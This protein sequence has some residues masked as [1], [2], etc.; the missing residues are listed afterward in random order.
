MKIFRIFLCFSL[1]AA[2]YACSGYD[3]SALVKRIE[4]LEKKVRT[5]QEQVSGINS[6][7][8]ALKVTLNAIDNQDVVVGIRA[9]ED[10]GK[11]GWEITYRK[12]GTV[13]IFPSEGT[14]SK[15]GVAEVGG[16]LYWTWGGSF[17]LDENGKRIPASAKNGTNGIT[18]KVKIEDDYWWV[19]YDEGATWTRLE[20]ATS[21]SGSGGGDSIFRSAYVEGNNL[22]IVLNNGTKLTIPVSSI[23]TP[24]AFDE[25]SIVFSVAA[26]SDVHI[27]NGYGS[28]AKFTSA[29][30]QLKNRAAEKDPDGLDAVMLVGDLI[31]TT[32]TGQISTLKSLYEGVFDPVKVPMIYTVG[33]HDMNPGCN[34]STNTVS[35]NAVFHTILG[36]DY[37]LTDKDQTMRRNFE[38]RHCVVGDYHIVGI[39]PNNANPVLYDANSTI[40]L[41]NV[42]EEI[43]TADPDRYVLVIT[44]PMIYN[45]VYGS[46]L[47]TYWYTSTLTDILNKYPQVVTFSGH[48]HFPLNDPRSIWQGKFTSMGC[49]SVSYM[50]FEGGDYENKSSNTV[51]KDAGDYSE[52]LLVQFD[53]NGFMRATRM[54]FFRSTVIGQPWEIA[55][56]AS[57]L[58][59][60]EKYNHTALS[61]ANTAPSLSTLDVV[62]GSVSGGSAPVTA[63]WAAGT[64]DEFVHHYGYTL[65]KGGSIVASKLIMSDFYRSP[66]TSMMKSSYSFSFGNLEEGDYSLEIKAYDSWGLESAPLEKSFTVGGANT[67]I[68][69]TDAAGSKTIGGSDINWTANTTGKPRSQ[70][71]DLSDG[72]KLTVVQLEPKDFK[73][74]WSFRTQRFSKNTAVASAAA[75]ITFEVNIGDAKYGET[76]SDLDGKSYTNQLGLSG[77]YLDAVADATV[78]I[79]YDNRSVRFGLFLDERKAQAVSNG[80]SGYPYVCFI[81]ECATGWMAQPWNF[82]PVPIHASQNYTWLWFNVSGDFATLNY[83]QPNKQYLPGT[84]SGANLIIGITCA[85]CASATPAASDINTDYDVI[86]QANPNKVNTNGGFTLTRK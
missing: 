2:L 18:P 50:A 3:D 8:A 33:N 63:T 57:D 70:Q 82:V 27:G 49:A 59:H 85:V 78:A 43:T 22:I 21:G 71:F 26:L 79:D 81:P 7:I 37:F 34:W 30:T 13:R 6:E 66:Q 24:T 67:T 47:G 4:D 56:P 28:E 80:K 54:D 76:L 77:L 62:C 16:V 42:L 55:P 65:R 31:N 72:S 23:E 51:L 61:A 39:T 1:A 35:Q 12:G 64:D 83:D 73:G 29:L 84:S 14:Q 32:N 69:V 74:A 46:T 40:W 36:D 68:W 17:L 5:I 52:G 60:L 20:K 53:V 19:S 45:T 25:N 44:H 11:A 86:Y 41:D 58:S 9:I 10:G 48:L 38:C 15:I 75:D